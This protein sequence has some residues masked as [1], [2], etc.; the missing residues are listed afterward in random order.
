MS[1]LGVPPRGAAVV[2]KCSALSCDT[3]GHLSLC[4]GET[5]KAGVPSFANSPWTNVHHG[6]VGL[7]PRGNRSLVTP[8]KGPR[9]VFAGWTIITG[10]GGMASTTP[11]NE[12]SVLMGCHL[13]TVW[14]SPLGFWA[15]PS[16]F[17]PPELLSWAP[18]SS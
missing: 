13:L 2:C 14:F 5:L 17:F 3:P 16:H 9:W 18:S 12:S 4:A 8:P 6:D 1:R 10:G 11:W 7:S 15:F